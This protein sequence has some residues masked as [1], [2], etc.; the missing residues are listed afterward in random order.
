MEQ[1]KIAVVAIMVEDASVSDKVNALLHQYADKIVGRMGIPYRE[2]N[3]NIISVVMDAMPNEINS[4]SGNLGR[5][6][7]V[8]VKVLTA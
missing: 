7:G 4:L 1:T 6:A 5:L 2:K 3:V 8:R